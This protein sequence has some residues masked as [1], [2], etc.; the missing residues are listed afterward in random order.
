MQ[1]IVNTSLQQAIHLPAELQKISPKNRLTDEAQSLYCGRYEATP[2]T[3]YYS[4]IHDSHRICRW[5]F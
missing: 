3:N 1:R 5:I 4:S 2:T